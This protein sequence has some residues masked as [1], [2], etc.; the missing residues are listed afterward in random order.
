[1]N[2]DFRSHSDPEDWTNHSREA[3]IKLL[4]A[5]ITAGLESGESVDFNVEAFKQQMRQRYF[6]DVSVRGS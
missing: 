2:G 6:P 3:A 5:A 4:Q 1:M